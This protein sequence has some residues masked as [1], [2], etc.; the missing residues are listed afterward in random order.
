VI[1]SQL[2]A[3]AKRR[4]EE[5]ILRQHELER[6]YALS[7]NL[8]LVDSPSPLAKHIA[9]Q[10]AQAFELS[11]V[12]F[13]DC[14]S[15]QV[16]RAGP[17][18]IPADECKLREVAVQGT[19]FHDAGTATSIVPISLGGQ[20]IGSLAVQ[21]SSV[22]DT[23]LHSIANLVA[24]GLERARAQQTASRAE[25]VR[26]SEELKSTLLD[27][28]AHEFKT[29]LTPIKAAVTSMLADGSCNPTHQELLRIV[30][31]ETDRLNSMVTEAIQMARIEAGKLQ[32]HTSPRTPAS[33]IGPSLEKICGAMEG[34][35]IEVYIPDDLPL[36]MADPELVRI[37]L[38]QLLS[39]AIKY[40]PPSSALTVRARAQDDSVAITVADGGPGIS[41]QEQ[42]RIFDK[43]YRSKE[44]LE[45]I[46]GTGMGLAIARQ[47]VTA[48]GGKI[49]VESDPGRGSA[50]SF[51][52]P[53]VGKEAAP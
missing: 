9:H 50:F 34:R 29:P 32:L 25:A 8:L 11:G 28:L 4:A 12:S 1:A 27:A 22:S 44:H 38:W 13:L 30:N 33:L 21:G 47:I 16:Y 26:Q 10:V 42:T 19:F 15:D 36:V 17:Q 23:A 20:V 3:S 37:A 46:P 6:L 45:L 35:K 40:T 31:E 5:A 51:T 52:L 18:D 49:W 41:Q 24:I 2:S 39:N 7:R 43:F 14:S 48:H 53:V